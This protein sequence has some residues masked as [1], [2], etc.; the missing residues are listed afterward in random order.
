MSGL[1]LFYGAT[2]SDTVNVF[3][4]YSAYV[5]RSAAASVVTA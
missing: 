4:A 1:S 3:A 2:R 5:T